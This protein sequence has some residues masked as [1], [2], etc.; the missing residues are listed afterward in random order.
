MLR[1]AACLMMIAVC[2]G[3]PVGP[4]HALDLP[5]RRDGD[6][7]ATNFKFNRDGT[8][9]DLKLH[10]TTLGAATGE[11]V[12]VLHGTSGSGAGL[13]TPSFAGQL[14]GPGQPLD[15]QKYFII[16]PDA[17]G[18]GAS[19]KPSDGLK[20]GFPSYSYDDMVEA[21]YR[22]VTEGLG[23]KHLRLVLGFSMGGMHAWLWGTTHPGFMDALVPMASQPSEMSSR[24]WMM[25]RLIIDTIRNDPDWQGGAYHRLLPARDQRRHPRFSKGRADP[26]GRRQT[27][28]RPA[29]SPVRHRCQRPALPVRRVP[30]L[31]SGG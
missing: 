17:I 19:A 9:A 6:F 5:D 18:H 13:L 2:S 4:A 31:Q 23:I 15:A 21:Q 11:P 24:N 29:R 27:A 30:R 20:A 7:L 10:Y 14:F 26:R 12:L 1:F 25:R 8:K 22:L 3:A 28:R 16:L